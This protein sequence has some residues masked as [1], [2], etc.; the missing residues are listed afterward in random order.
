MGA[1]L[2]LGY[3]DNYSCCATCVSAFNVLLGPQFSYLLNSKVTYEFDGE[4]TVIKEFLALKSLTWVPLVV[5][6]ISLI[7]VYFLAQTTS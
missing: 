3:S 4:K 6:V 5:W 7:T 1:Y 2:F